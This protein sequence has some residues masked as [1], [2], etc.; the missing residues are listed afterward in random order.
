MD[1]KACGNYVNGQMMNRAYPLVAHKYYRETN[2]RHDTSQFRNRLGQLKSLYQFIKELQKKTGI[3]RRQDG[4][5]AAPSS[6]W[7]D[8]TKVQSMTYCFLSNL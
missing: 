3:G 7:D 4:W 1:Q 8:V 5:I 2:L 6:W